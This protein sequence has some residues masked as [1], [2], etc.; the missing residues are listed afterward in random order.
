MWAGVADCHDPLPLCCR[1]PRSPLPHSDQTLLT[2]LVY[3]P[4][5]LEAEATHAVGKLW[6]TVLQGVGY[7]PNQTI[8]FAA[9]WE[10]VFK[11]KKKA[12][13]A[14]APQAQMVSRLS[15]TLATFAIFQLAACLNFPW[16]C[17]PQ[18]LG[19]H[20][21]SDRA[22]MKSTF[23][24]RGQPELPSVCSQHLISRLPRGMSQRSWKFRNF[25][26]GPGLQVVLFRGY[27]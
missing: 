3:F 9:F 8:Y 23:L 24:P 15:E 26:E 5:V 7:F 18:A 27:F 6:N 20:V 12:F 17:S 4:E 1:D 22:V 10:A 11:K 19:C 2:F 16:Y 25:S 21:C 13:S 14:S